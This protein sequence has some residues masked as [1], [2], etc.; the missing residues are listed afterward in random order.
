MLPSS[1]TREGGQ[2]SS[3]AGRQVELG[4]WGYRTEFEPW[5]P[6]LGSDIVIEA[7]NYAS[8]IWQLVILAIKT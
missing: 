4:A 6:G 5:P 3:L 8:L 2:T 1:G 7:G